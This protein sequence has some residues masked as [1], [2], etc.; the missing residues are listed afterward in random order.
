LLP[1]A[2]LPPRGA[3]GSFVSCLPL[4]SNSLVA[5]GNWPRPVVCT[6]PLSGFGPNSAPWLQFQDPA[7]TFRCGARLSLTFASFHLVAFAS[8]PSD[9]SQTSR[10][11]FRFRSMSS[12]HVLGLHATP[13]PCGGTEP[14]DPLICV[15]FPLRRL[16][17]ESFVLSADDFPRARISSSRRSAFTSRFS[18][19]RGPKW[20]S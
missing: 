17:A 3:R 6:L 10:H 12:D 19:P 20:Q 16:I 1:P 11:H 15:R 18:G 2:R 8:R 4:L 7:F 14:P 5:L 13:A 9:V